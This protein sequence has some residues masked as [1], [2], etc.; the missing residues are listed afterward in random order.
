[1]KIRPTARTSRAARPGPRL[2]LVRA[3]VVR[4]AAGLRGAGRRVAADREVVALR[5]AG[6]RED[7]VEREEAVVRGRARGEVF[8][9]IPA[10]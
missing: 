9:A 10:P 7:V 2:R 5:A 6:L 8:V 1:M 4:R 3:D